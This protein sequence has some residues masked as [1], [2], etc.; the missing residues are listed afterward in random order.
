MVEKITGVCRNFKLKT[1]S[2]TYI[3]TVLIY[4]MY[5]NII[6]TFLYILFKN[7]LNAVQSSNKFGQLATV[8]C[9]QEGNPTIYTEFTVLEFYC[10]NYLNCSP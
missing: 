6:P 7:I 9:F 10:L 5:K 4:A 1:D 8:G 2:I 3:N